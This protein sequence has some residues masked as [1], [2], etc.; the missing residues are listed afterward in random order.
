MPSS[1]LTNARKAWND[2]K[3]YLIQLKNRMEFV[4]NTELEILGHKNHI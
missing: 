3:G 4:R 1:E 2:K